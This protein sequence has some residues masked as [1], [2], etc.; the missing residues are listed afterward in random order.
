[1]CHV[2]HVSCPIYHSRSL[3]NL[4]K[5]FPIAYISD[6]LLQEVTGVVFGIEQYFIHEILC[7]TFVGKSN[8]ARISG[9]LTL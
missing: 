4:P 2:F 7:G 9:D 6:I 8:T 1:M 3:S 5:Q